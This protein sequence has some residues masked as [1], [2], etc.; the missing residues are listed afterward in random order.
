MSRSLV[1]RSVLDG[2]LQYEDYFEAEGSLLSAI[3]WAKRQ[4]AIL[5]E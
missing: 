4:F 3:D 1:Y 2:S 5:F